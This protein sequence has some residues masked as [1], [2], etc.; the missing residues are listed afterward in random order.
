MQN[1]KILISLLLLGFSL[2]IIAQA[3]LIPFTAVPATVIESSRDSINTSPDRPDR[4]R[5]TF[6]YEYSYRGQSYTS[7][8]FTYGNRNKSSGVCSYRIGDSVLAYV[9]QRDPTYAVIDRSVSRF[10]YAI[11]ALSGFMVAHSLLDFVVGPNSLASTP[12][13]R[14]IHQWLGAGIG[15]TLL[16]GGLGYFFYTLILAA[17]RNCVN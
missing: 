16:V 6:S 9:N 8:R 13:L 2:T 15:I 1:Y 17:T 5:Y 4:Y 14:T 11:A 3:R 12:G 7:S 10:I